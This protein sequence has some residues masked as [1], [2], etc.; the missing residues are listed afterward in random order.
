M[1]CLLIMTFCDWCMEQ[2]KAFNILTLK[3][4]TLECNYFYNDKRKKDIKY[5]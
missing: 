3:R 1:H 4:L 5:F 2:K